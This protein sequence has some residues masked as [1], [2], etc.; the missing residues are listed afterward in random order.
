M[1]KHAY[2]RYEISKYGI[3]YIHTYIYIY[4]YAC[5]IPLH[6]HRIQVH[7]FQ[8]GNTYM[9]LSMGQIELCNC[10]KLNCLK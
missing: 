1:T 4:I 8:S 7:F 6:C 9:V 3:M 10:A 2:S 5:R